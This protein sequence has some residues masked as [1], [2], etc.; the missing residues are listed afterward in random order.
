M[1]LLRPPMT[2]GR[3]PLAS[4]KD[5]VGLV[6]HHPI[7]R[8]CGEQGVLA[9]D[10]PVPMSPPDPAVTAHP[11]TKDSSS[12]SDYEHYD[13]SSKPPVA[14]STFYSEHP[15]GPRDPNTQLWGVPTD[16]PS[17]SPPPQTRCAG[18]PATLCSPE[19]TGWNR[20]L[21][22]VPHDRVSVCPSCPWQGEG[23]P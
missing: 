10:G 2:T 19:R 16:V 14:L 5:Q 22:K 9:G 17:L 11:I 7:L 3:C 18:S 15:K 12:D 20:S 13:F 6:G 8:G 4:P 1:S 23:P 21:P